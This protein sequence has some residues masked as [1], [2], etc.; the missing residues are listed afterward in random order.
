MLVQRGSSGFDDGDDD[1]VTASEEEEVE[2]S[3]VG[4]VVILRWSGRI[5]LGA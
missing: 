5:I 2:L 1:T 3:S 4:R